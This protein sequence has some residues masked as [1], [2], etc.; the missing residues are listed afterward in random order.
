MAIAA[1]AGMRKVAR[2]ETVRSRVVL[3]LVGAE[4]TAA[5]HMQLFAGLGGIRPGLI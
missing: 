1:S 5:V 3:E 2:G 4:G